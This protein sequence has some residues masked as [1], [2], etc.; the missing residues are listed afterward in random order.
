MTQPA[1]CAV[2]QELYDALPPK[3]TELDGENGW[4]LA[5]L[6]D[7]LTAPGMQ[8][9]A[10]YGLDLPD[11][12]PGWTQ[13][14]NLNAITARQAQFLGQFVGV[15][16]PAGLT[17][18]EAR[19]L[20]ASRPGYARGRPATIVAA[21]Q[22]LLT[23]GRT[24][25]LTERDTSPYHHHL[26]TWASETPDPAAVAAIIAEVKPAGDIIAYDTI[27]G[28]TYGE[29]LASLPDGA[30]TYGGREAMYPTYG[31]IKEYQP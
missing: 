9:L 1:I 18:A 12:T 5:Y 16:V 19:A 23:G 8:H 27:P 13:L 24:V 15:Q 21:V 3:W 30:K 7:A 6:C 11:G 20:I 14:F 2:G 4:P 29:I 22:T 25:V 26:Q 17:G 31:D 10:D 28:P